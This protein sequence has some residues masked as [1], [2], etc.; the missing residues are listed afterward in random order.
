MLAFIVQTEFGGVDRV[1]I[2]KYDL[3]VFTQFL[4][5]DIH[6]ALTPPDGARLFRGDM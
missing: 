6:K 5:L 4:I 3:Q 2:S 1:Q